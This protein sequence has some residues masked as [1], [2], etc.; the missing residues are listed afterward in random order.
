MT[1]FFP[2]F[3]LIFIYPSFIHEFN[4]QMKPKNDRPLASQKPP[5]KIKNSPRWGE[6]NF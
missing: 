1:N 6:T 3:F 4:V 5:Q 2:L